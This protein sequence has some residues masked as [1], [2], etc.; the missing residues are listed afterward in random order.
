MES[1]EI[2]YI[3][4]LDVISLLMLNPNI[5]SSFLSVLSNRIIMLNQ[6]ISNLSQDTLNKKV[7]N[8]LLDEYKKQNTIYLTF[9]YTRKK[10]AELLNIPRPSLSRELTKMRQEG[11][12]NFNKN[13]IEILQIDL[14]EQALFK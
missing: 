3:E 11:I 6:R 2:M 1:S 8:F 10:M 4:K 7:S 14:L 9:P 12:I 5:L 13:G